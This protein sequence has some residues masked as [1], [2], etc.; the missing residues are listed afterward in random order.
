M[1]GLSKGRY[2]ETFAGEDVVDIPSST[3]FLG[4]NVEFPLG[5][6][7]KL[8]IFRGMKILLLLWGSSLNWIIFGHHFYTF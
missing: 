6:F 5:V 4:S 7:R 8:N 1:K 2:D 3:F